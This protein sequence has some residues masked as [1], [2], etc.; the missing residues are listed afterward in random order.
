MKRSTKFLW[1]IFGWA[2]A[3][4]L[5]LSFLAERLG[6]IGVLALGLLS[7]LVGFLALRDV[8]RRALDTLRQNVRQGGTLGSG[9]VIEG[10]LHGIGAIL[11]ILPGFLTDL[12][13]LVLIAPSLR[14]L[15]ARRFASRR[16]AGD[17]T[18]DLAPGEWHSINEPD[19]QRLPRRDPRA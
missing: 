15:V 19:P 5:V 16:P 14:T 3:E 8:G 10:S 11:L 17:G 13:G 2:M 1:I 9:D 18:I 12:I 4:F 6:W 7:S